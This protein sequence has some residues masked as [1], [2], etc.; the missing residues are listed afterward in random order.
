V[1]DKIH[2]FE[3]WMTKLTVLNSESEINSSEQLKTKPTILNSGR[4]N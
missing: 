4:Q 3:Q 2:S 1:E